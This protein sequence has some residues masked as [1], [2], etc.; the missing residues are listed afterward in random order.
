MEFGEG[1][2]EEGGARNLGLSRQVSGPKGPAQPGY[3]SWRP[4]SK[5]GPSFGEN[6]APA[7]SASQFCGSQE[8]AG[9][10]LW[11]GVGPGLRPSLY[12]TCLLPSPQP[13]PGARLQR[14]LHPAPASTPTLPAPAST[15]P[16]PAPAST[17]HPPLQPHPPRS[18]LQPPHSQPPLARF[19][20]PFTAPA[21]PRPARPFQPP[22]SLRTALL[23]LSQ[24][25]VRALDNMS[26]S[27]AVG[28]KDLARRGGGGKRE[29]GG[30]EGSTER[31]GEEEGRKGSTEGEGQEGKCHS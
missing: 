9:L 4:A 10:L 16:P 26:C 12:G 25:W 22:P 18:P 24:P 1:R 21:P 13:P 31:K 17:P 29:E 7:A 3:P 20:H 23:P 2:V 15:P 14:P 8:W 11:R 6:T 5:P 27:V 28:V 30:K 19:S